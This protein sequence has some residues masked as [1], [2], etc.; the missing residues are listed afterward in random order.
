M[1]VTDLAAMPGSIRGIVGLI[2][3]MR[4]W[5]LMLGERMMLCA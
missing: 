3:G 4:D 2:L 5:T 1:A